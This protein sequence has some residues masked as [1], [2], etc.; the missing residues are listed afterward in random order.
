M[1]RLNYKFTD[2]LQD[3]DLLENELCQLE[4]ALAK[5]HPLIGGRLEMP[6]CMNLPAIGSDGNQDCLQLG[7]PHP[8]P[9]N[10]GRNLK[11]KI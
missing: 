9:V 11:C 1:C 10:K 4:Y 7:M 5:R 8:E 2:C 3:C 6:E